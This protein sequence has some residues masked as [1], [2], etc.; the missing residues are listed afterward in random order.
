MVILTILVSQNGTAFLGRVPGVPIRTPNVRR[1]GNYTFSNALPCFFNSLHDIVPVQA[2]HHR[3]PPPAR[4]VCETKELLMFQCFSKV[5]KVPIA[6]PGTPSA[7][8]AAGPRGDRFGKGHSL[9]L[10][11]NF[12]IFF[13]LHTFLKKGSLFVFLQKMLFAYVLQGFQRFFSNIRF[14]KR[15]HRVLMVEKVCPIPNW[16]PADPGAGRWVAPGGRGLLEPRNC[17][18]SN[19][20]SRFLRYP[21]PVPGPRRAAARAARSKTNELPRFLERPPPRASAARTGSRLALPER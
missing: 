12:M 16:S 19:A 1:L 18:F 13:I 10:S 4:P 3:S 15:L 2:G 17:C 21:L 20:F 11:W 8:P 6:G 9:K 14:Y 5:L 7:R